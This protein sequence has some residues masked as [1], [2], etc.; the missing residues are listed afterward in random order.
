MTFIGI[1]SL[2][3]WPPTLF[4][5]P[6][7]WP[8]YGPHHSKAPPLAPKHWTASSAVSTIFTPTTMQAVPFSHYSISD[9]RASVDAWEGG[10]TKPLVGWSPGRAMVGLKA[11]NSDQHQGLDSV[12]QTLLGS[13]VGAGTAKLHWCCTAA[14]DL[15]HQERKHCF[16]SYAA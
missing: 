5:L 9:H 6:P 8:W 4:T 1:L 7:N 3:T 16:S 2:P 10:L 15:T 14:P 12:P 13:G 11:I